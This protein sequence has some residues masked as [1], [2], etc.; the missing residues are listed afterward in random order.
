MAMMRNVLLRAFS[1]CL[2]RVAAMELFI[3]MTGGCGGYWAWASR[4][5]R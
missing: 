2:L 5:Q 1:Q 3:M 4:K